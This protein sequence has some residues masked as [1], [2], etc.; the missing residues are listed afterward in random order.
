MD[1]FF[2]QDFIVLISSAPPEAPSLPLCGSMFVCSLILVEYCVEWSGW[3]CAVPL[4]SSKESE[5]ELG[6]M[7]HYQELM[8]LIVTHP[9]EV[10]MTLHI[11]SLYDVRRDIS[12]Y[13]WKSSEA[14]P[15][16]DAV[17]DLSSPATVPA[18]VPGKG[19]PGLAKSHRCLW[20]WFTFKV[21]SLQR[22]SVIVY[23]TTGLTAYK[24]RSFWTTSKRSGVLWYQG[25]A[26]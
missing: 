9:F 14:R 5:K 15:Y 2:P 4:T 18:Q 1:V 26:S 23:C 8:R 11:L 3:E 24:P 12:P 25:I 19:G 6:D 22:G 7:L 20:H 17:F 13:D 16:P 10:N 21:P